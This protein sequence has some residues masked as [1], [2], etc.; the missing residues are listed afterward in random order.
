VESLVE[1]LLHVARSLCRVA[2]LR[3]G[4]GAIDEAACLVEQ[5][6]D[7][8]AERSKHLSRRPQRRPLE[9]LQ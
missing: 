3:Q 6:S 1:E 5:A 7:L 8:L 2:A 9:E 4:A